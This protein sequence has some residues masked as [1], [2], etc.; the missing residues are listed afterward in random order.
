MGKMH[1]VFLRIGSLAEI[2]TAS[3]SMPLP[4]GRRV[5]VRTSRGIELG[6]VIGPCHRKSHLE[7]HSEGSSPRG[8]RV[9]RPTTNEDELLIRRLERHKRRAVE[10]CRRKLRLAGCQVTLLD[11]DQLFDGGTLVMHFLGDADAEARSIT[12]TIA[13]EYESVIQSRHF[14]KLLSDGCGPG[15]G[16]SQGSGSQGSGQDG[17]G[18][19]GSCA[20]CAAGCGKPKT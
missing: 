17:G 15:C 5:I 8:S 14:A 20:T 6:E 16:T 4:R 12:Q 11:I 19:S 10:E 7:N 13:K 9:L 18:C 3:A 1:P 2:H